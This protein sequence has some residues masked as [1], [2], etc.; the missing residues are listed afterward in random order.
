MLSNLVH[1]DDSGLLQVTVSAKPQTVVISR[2][3]PVYRIQNSILSDPRRRI[4]LAKNLRGEP[5]VSSNSW[6]R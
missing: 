6:A 3:R 2:K 1:G 4:I 5:T